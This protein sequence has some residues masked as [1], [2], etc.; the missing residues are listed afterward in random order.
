MIKKYINLNSL[1]IYIFKQNQY[2]QIS[3]NNYET[4]FLKFKVKQ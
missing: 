3:E 4:T 1:N 2:K